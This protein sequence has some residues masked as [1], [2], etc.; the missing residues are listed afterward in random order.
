[1][2]DQSVSNYTKRINRQMFSGFLLGLALCILWVG[3]TPVF[4][5]AP[6]GDQGLWQELS[7]RS[8]L[9]G[10]L[11]G[12][13]MKLEDAGIKF[14]LYQNFYYGVNA[15]GG[16]NTHDARKL[17]N[18]TDLFGQF[19]LGKLGLIEDAE[20]LFQVKNHY[21]HNVNHKVGAL[22]DP[23]DDADGNE[24]L[25]IDQ[26]WYQ[27]SFN[28]K[29]VQVRIGYLDQQTAL[30]RNAYANSEDKQFMTTYLDNNN[31]IIPLAIGLGASIFINPNEHIGFVIGGADAEASLHETG[32]KT[33]FNSDRDFFGY[34]QTD[35]KTQLNS[36]N[37]DLPGTYRFG[38][39][40]DP[41]NRGKFG[42]AKRDNSDVG[43]YSSFDQMLSREQEESQQG[44]GCFLRYGYRHSE[45]NRIS[46]FW[47]TGFQYTG[48]LPNRDQD[49]TGIGMY[50]AIGSS[51][52]ERYVNDDFE[53]ETGY[54][55]YH[56]FVVTPWMTLAPDV[57]YKHNPGGLKTARDSII[58]GLRM[59]I[60]Y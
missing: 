31:A 4:G 13:R 47:S 60:I 44:L 12:E 39:I 15:K 29:E 48:L 21:S 33:T 51:K 7:Q 19:D 58:L 45:L 30:D 59:R 38:L 42:S 53:G 36:A 24:D 10:D 34:F 56:S 23:F 32:F 1:M 57:Q 54:E 35:L 43:F 5:E 55:L 17:S 27:Q 16:L 8:R 52:Y 9:L 40:F 18:S 26:C 20:I 49:L 22:S 37:G 3:I 28:D 50:S 11:G 2:K 14:S 41:R 46:N 6:S 25:Y